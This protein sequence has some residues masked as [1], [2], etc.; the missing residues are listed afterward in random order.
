MGI[1]V[2]IGVLYGKGQFKD[3]VHVDCCMKICQTVTNSLASI[4]QYSTNR[5][6]FVP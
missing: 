1:H 3:S 5:A 4:H 6:L 2:F